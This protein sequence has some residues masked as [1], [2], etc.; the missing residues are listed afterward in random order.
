MKTKPWY[1]V[2]KILNYV[3]PGLVTTISVINPG[4]NGYEKAMFPDMIY[5]TA[6]KPFVYRT[7]LPAMVRLIQ[8]PIPMQV[9]DLINKSLSNVSILKSAIDKLG[10]EKDYLLDYSVAFILLYLFLLGF[11]GAFKYLFTRLISTN[12]IFLNVTSFVAIV[13]LPLLFKYYTYIYDFPTLFLFTLGLGLMAAEQWNLYMLVFIFA[14]FNKET[15]ILLAFIYFI[16]N[17]PN[18]MAGKLFLKLLIMQLVFYA[19]IKLVVTILF[20]NNPGTFLEFHLF[21]HNLIILRNIDLLP[22][23]L[24]LLPIIILVFYKW[25]EKPKLLK[26]GLWVLVPLVSIAVFYG[27]IDEYRA[28]YEAYPIICLLIIYSFGKLIGVKLETRPNM[29]IG[30]S[31]SL[32]YL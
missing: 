17:F 13:G 12:E 22:L 16:H 8:A 4:I 25:R 15:S 31:A 14:T 24:I 27:F 9:R 29:R 11:L 5:G 2:I 32:A 18:I 28:Y 21:D 19:G 7:L 6:Y 10:W 23:L 3:F 20:V 26:D 1:W 30:N